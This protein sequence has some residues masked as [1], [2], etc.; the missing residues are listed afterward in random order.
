MSADERIVR[1]IDALLEKA[2][3]V[4]ATHKPNPSGMLGF[5]TLDMG[6][7][8]EWRSQCVSML[9]SVAGDAG[10]YT[11]DFVARVQEG[12]RSHVQAGAGILRALKEDIEQGYLTSLKTLISAE[13]FSDFLDMSKHLL[14]S[15]YKDPSASL[16][17]AVLENALRQ[18]GRNAGV[19]VKKTDS[20]NSLNQK[21]AQGSVYNR[22]TYKQIDVWISIR[23]N[24]DHGHFDEYSSQDVHDMH[25][26]IHDFMTK[27][28]E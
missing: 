11:S 18:I 2:D 13:V 25:K 22:L 8:A 1:R 23:N 5:S 9:T 10:T 4:L 26:G 20:L 27:Y 7:F 17:G 16:S 6:S 12:F 3:R 21:L 28:L 24:A 14:D 15:G 19:N